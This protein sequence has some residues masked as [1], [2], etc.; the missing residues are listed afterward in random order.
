MLMHEEANKV[1]KMTQSA[2]G[3][4]D[5]LIYVLKSH[6]KLMIFLFEET[7][8]CSLMTIVIHVPSNGV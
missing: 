2:S 6:W 5:G 4:A 3:G 8:L 7:V 1:P